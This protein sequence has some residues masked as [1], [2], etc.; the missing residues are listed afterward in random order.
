MKIRNTRLGQSPRRHQKS[1]DWPKVKITREGIDEIL[2][3]LNTHAKNDWDWA[4]PDANP[5]SV[6]FA[7]RI[8]DKSIAM[9]FKLIYG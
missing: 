1:F 2:D 9:M 6:A 5:E 8:K 7:V 3:W 4:W